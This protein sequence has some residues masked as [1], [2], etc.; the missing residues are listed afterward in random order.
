MLAHNLTVKQFIE[1]RRYYTSSLITL[2][3]TDVTNVN[4]PQ[5]LQLLDLNT[6]I[7]IYSYSLS[8]G[9]SFDDASDLLGSLSIEEFAKTTG[10]FQTVIPSFISL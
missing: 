3:I 8:E 1:L 2:G 6:Q 9:M 4:Y 5:K 10:K 7:A